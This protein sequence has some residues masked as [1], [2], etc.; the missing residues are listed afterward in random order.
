MSTYI[1]SYTITFQQLFYWIASLNFLIMSCPAKRCEKLNYCKFIHYFQLEILM[2]K[3]S[4]YPS[5][6]N[7][8]AL[9]TTKSYTYLEYPHK[10]N[11]HCKDRIAHTHET[12]WV[13]FICPDLAINKDMSLHQNSKHFTACESILQPVTQNKNQ[14]QAFPRLVGSRWWLGC[15]H[16]TK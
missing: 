8:K 7:P 14:R 2:I 10:R 16:N 9:K 12:R 6:T 5:R 4:P 11:N 3:T 15:L 1:L 13:S